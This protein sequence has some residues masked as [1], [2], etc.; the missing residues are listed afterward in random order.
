MISGRKHANEITPISVPRGNPIICREFARGTCE[1]T[2]EQP[3]CQL[4]HSY[5]AYFEVPAG[6]VAEQPTAF[7]LGSPVRVVLYP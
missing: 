2:C 1:R 5:D 3:G 7:L 6:S 4:D